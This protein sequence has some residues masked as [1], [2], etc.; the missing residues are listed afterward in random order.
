MCALLNYVYKKK[1]G[2]EMTGMKNRLIG[3]SGGA[4]AAWLLLSFLVAYVPLMF[5]D[6]PAG[7]SVILMLLMAIPLLGDVLCAGLYIGAV[8][9]ALH[10]PVSALSVILFGFAVYYLFTRVLPFARTTLFR[11][12]TAA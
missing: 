12:R 8:I 1:K 4:G 6:C 10:Q 9:T 2:K 5:L 3:A 7:L 11:S